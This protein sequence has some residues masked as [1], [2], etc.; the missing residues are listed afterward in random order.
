MWKATTPMDTARNPHSGDMHIKWTMRR[1]AAVTAHLAAQV[2]A[3]QVP[4]APGSRQASVRQ[5]DQ[6]LLGQM[7]AHHQSPSRRALGPPPAMV[8]RPDLQQPVELEL[9]DEPG[10]VERVRLRLVELVTAVLEQDLANTMQ[11]LAA[12]ELSGR[13]VQVLHL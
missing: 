8:S 6:H 13:E 1:V 9:L 2:R 12:Q 5:V 7:P 4:L 3:Q 10:G 11:R